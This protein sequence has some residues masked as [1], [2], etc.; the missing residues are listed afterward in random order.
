MQQ[1]M[2]KGVLA[3]CVGVGGGSILTKMVREDLVSI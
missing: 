1:E 3:G 2:G